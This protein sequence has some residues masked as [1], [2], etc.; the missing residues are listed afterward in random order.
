MSSSNRLLLDY[1]SVSIYAADVATLAP[2]TWLNDNVISFWMDYCQHELFKEHSERFRF[3]SPT[4]TMILMH[5][6]GRTHTRTR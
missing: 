1:H 4:T 5:E 2:N 6:E 3:V